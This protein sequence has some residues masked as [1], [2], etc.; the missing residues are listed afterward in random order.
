MSTKDKTTEE[1]AVNDATTKSA[2]PE[3][4]E[5]HIPKGNA[6]DDPNMFVGIN[7]V[8]YILPKGKSSM[9]PPEVAEEIDRAL[10]AQQKQ[11][12]HVDEML[13]KAK[14]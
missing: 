5:R 11:D 1:T 2:K 10:R 3:R 9:V 14:Q 4:V 8:N 6:N 13:D 12:E 7:G